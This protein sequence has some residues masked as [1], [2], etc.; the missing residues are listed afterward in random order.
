MLFNAFQVDKHILQ[1]T[2]ISLAQLAAHCCPPAGAVVSS[3]HAPLIPPWHHAS[4]W[5]RP[6]P[7]LLSR[8]FLPVG[9]PLVCFLP[10]CNATLSLMMD[11]AWKAVHALFGWEPLARLL[12]LGQ[13][14]LF[15]QRKFTMTLYYPGGLFPQKRSLCS[16]LG[17]WQ[18]LPL[19][20]NKQQHRARNTKREMATWP[21]TE[22]TRRLRHS[23]DHCH[24][25]SRSRWGWSCLPLL[26]GLLLRQLLVRLIAFIGYG[27]KVWWYTLLVTF[28]QSVKS[29]GGKVDSSFTSFVQNT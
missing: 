23:C 19:E 6:W 8:R 1:V 9:T 16:E 22:Q 29:K 20:L 18:A 2:N 11:Q 14:L 25:L 28:W 15:Q 10:P 24:L 26:A 7:Q 12:F 5:Q 3:R 21:R 4:P 17:T 13:D 27:L